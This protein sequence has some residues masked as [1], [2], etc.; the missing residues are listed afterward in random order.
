MTSYK[1]K[2][3]LASLAAALGASVLAGCS[4][5]N[6]MTSR[7][8]QHVTPYRVTI[9]Q[10]NFVS[11]DA[12]AKLHAGMT[13]DEVRAALGTPLLT[14]MFHP[15]RWDYIF[16]FKRG[17]TSVVEQRDVVVNFNGDTVVSWSGANDLPS[18]QDLIEMIDSS[19]SERSWLRLRKDQRASDNAKAKP[20][21]A[22]AAAS[23][24]SAASAEPANQRAADAANNA[25]AASSPATTV[26]ARNVPQSN[27]VHAGPTSSVQSAPEP[28]FHLTTPNHL[29]PAGGSSL[30]ARPPGADDAPASGATGS[31]N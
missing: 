21:P 19:R 10:G 12:A 26:R 1:H 29:R 3:R 6:S 20:A 8:V 9:V 11:S 27:V 25:L 17:S 14:D 16:Y 7:I 28:Q 2:M 30:L 31:S 15:E 13:R 23:G 24:A 18:N 5:Y 4:T 22:A